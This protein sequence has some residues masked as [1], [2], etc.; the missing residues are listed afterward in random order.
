MIMIATVIIE[1]TSDEYGNNNNN[2]YSNYDITSHFFGISINIVTIT[3]IIIISPLKIITVGIDRIPYSVAMFG[4]S[5][6]FN[7]T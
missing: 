5:S 7:F 1:Y 3:I 4:D 6:V 2:N